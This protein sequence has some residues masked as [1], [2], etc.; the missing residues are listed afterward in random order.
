[1][2]RRNLLLSVSFILIF[3]AIFGHSKKLKFLKFEI[4]KDLEVC[5][6]NISYEAAE[7]STVYIFHVDFEILQQLSDVLIQITA[8]TSR[9]KNDK[10]FQYI[11]LNT[12]VDFCKFQSNPAASILFQGFWN[13]L[14]KNGINLKCPLQ[15]SV[16]NI[17][18]LRFPV[19]FF[20]IISNGEIM[21]EF[22]MYGRVG[23][24]KKLRN[25]LMTQ[26]IVKIT[27]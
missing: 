20:P 19:S 5:R 27:S 12:K 3:F 11:L 18:H 9:D 4:K 13:E 14:L 15:K 2:S 23:S 17:P 1:M 26:M 21:A 24:V 22:K 7:D 25:F 10:D 16:I 6:A 8:K